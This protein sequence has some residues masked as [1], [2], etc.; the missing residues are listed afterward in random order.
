MGA[1][2]PLFHLFFIFLFIEVRGV[3]VVRQSHIG[4][5]KKAAQRLV[6]L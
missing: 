1:I 6:P 4:G 3:S 2:D 5:Q